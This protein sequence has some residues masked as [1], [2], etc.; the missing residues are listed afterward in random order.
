[1]IQPV[2]MS[3]EAMNGRFLQQEI[4]ANNLANVSTAGF[5]RDKMF[6]DVLDA[7]DPKAATHPVTVF[8]QGNLRQTESPYDLAVSG[9]GFFAV[10]TPQGVRYT[11]NGRFTVDNEGYLATDSGYRV[12][13]EH[14]SIYAKGKFEAASD[15]TVK[16]DNA[17]GDKIQLVA[18]ENTGTLKKTGVGLFEKTS[19]TAEKP[20]S[21]EI[22]QG[23]LEESNVNTLDEMVA[24]MTIYRYF[25]ADQRVL[26]S[27]DAIMNKVANE[28]GR[29]N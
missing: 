11:R 18:F 14:G 6:Q 20:A 28:V 29:V 19:A 21:A 26:Q 13:G 24:M 15:G 1:M 12:L 3:T 2:K 4:I 8:E 25:E 16:L 27:Q 5:K 22:H 23:F 17:A 7:E 10:Q 9:D